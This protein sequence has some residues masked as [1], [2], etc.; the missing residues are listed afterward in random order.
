[1]E[2]GLDVLGVNSLKNVKKLNYLVCGE[3]G[4]NVIIF[5]CLNEYLLSLTWWVVFPLCLLNG[6]VVLCF[7]CACTKWF[8]VF[9]GILHPKYYI[10]SALRES[11]A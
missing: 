4:K 11:T 1:M 10:G 7:H 6:F 3:F 8:H 5:Y 2:L 9:A